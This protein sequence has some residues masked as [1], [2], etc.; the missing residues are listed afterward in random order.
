MNNPRGETLGL[1]VGWVRG[2]G[3]ELGFMLSIVLD[4][5]LPSIESFG[6][7]GWTPGPDLSK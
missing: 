1:G 7:V 3:V 2:G 6:G 5:D 4:G